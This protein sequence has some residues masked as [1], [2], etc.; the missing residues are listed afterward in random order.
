LLSASHLFLLYLSFDPE[1]EETDGPASACFSHFSR[2]A[3]FSTVM[4]FRYDSL[5]HELTFTG[6]QIMSQKIE[7]LMEEFS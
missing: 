2:L 7:L 6:L 1:G 3:H 4:C 5:K